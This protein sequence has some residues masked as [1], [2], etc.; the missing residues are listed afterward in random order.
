M[1]YETFK[2]K[3]IFVES[4]GQILPDADSSMQEFWEKASVL[5]IADK[6]H[7]SLQYQHMER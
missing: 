7:G 2:L 4:M 6:T 5:S 1:H 3:E